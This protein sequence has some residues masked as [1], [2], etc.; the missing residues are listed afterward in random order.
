MP[1]I[2]YKSQE[3]SKSAF[4]L[5]VDIF[6]RMLAAGL[7][8]A[9]VYVS[10]NSIFLAFGSEVTGYTLQ[11]KNESGTY[12]TVDKVDFAGGEKHFPN[13]DTSS[14]RLILTEELS[15]GAKKGCDIASQII[16][17]AL[18][19]VLIYTEVWSCG[20]KDRNLVN[21]GRDKFDKFKGAKAAGMAFVPYLVLSVVISLGN[22]N[23][24]PI[25]LNSTYAFANI[26]FK[27]F[28]DAVLGNFSW[29]SPLLLLLPA[30]VVIVYC[31]AVYTIG[32]KQILISEKILYTE[33]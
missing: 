15:K 25:K 28:I 20:E 30:L 12:E 10:M 32:Y 26:A 21:Y 11:A 17:L 24:L 22:L 4:K 3:G 6:L 14:M 18:F 13:I 27:P 5:A 29:Y 9:I 8:C 2:K 1:Y 19:C 16:M 7:M 31:Q 23:I 33:K